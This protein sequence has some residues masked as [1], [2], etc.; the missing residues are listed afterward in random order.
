[1]FILKIFMTLLE[2]VF[3]FHILDCTIISTE[4]EKLLPQLQHSQILHHV[5]TI[6][7]FDAGECENESEEKFS[8]NPLS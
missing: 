5:P 1:M 3:A 8:S 7:F 4:A 2:P 6:T